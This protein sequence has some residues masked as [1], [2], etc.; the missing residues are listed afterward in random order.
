MAN[1]DPLWMSL[2]LAS[3]L[4]VVNVVKDLINAKAEYWGFIAAKNNKTTILVA[5]YEKVFDRDFTVHFVCVAAK[6]VKRRSISFFR[7]RND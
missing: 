1:G 2:S 3:F 6:N 5:V 7:R 4:Y